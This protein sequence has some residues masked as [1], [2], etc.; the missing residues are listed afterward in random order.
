MT[1]RAAATV[2]VVDDELHNRKLVKLLL[3]HEGYVVVTASRGDEVLAAVARYAP[4]LILLDVMTPGMNGYQVATE[5]KAD[6][7]TA[8]IPIIMV[9]ALDDR[10]ARLAGLEAGAE[11]FLTKPI[12]PAELRLRVR[13]MLRIKAHGE[14]QRTESRRENA[15]L[16]RANVALKARESILVVESLTDALTGVG[17]R[18]MLERAVAAEI[19]RVERHGGA[20][21]ALMMDIDH[22]KRVNDEYGHA[23]G[24]RVLARF[25]ALLRAQTRPTDIV[26]RFGGEEFVVLMPHTPLVPAAAKAEQIR[27]AIAAE[28]IEPL[29]TP[30]TSS[31]GL[32]EL[33]QGEDAASFLGRS[34]AALYKAK[35]GGR[36]RVVAFRASDHACGGIS[37]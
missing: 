31:F 35:D 25:A 29:A 23:A 6:P 18:R 36:N 34:D 3:V 14:W 37:T 1:L 26:T 32:A 33:A 9:T 13:N 19:N 4:D 21:S 22:F 12:E 17:N 27:A 24:D 16:S 11:E 10:T 20:L 30:L 15:V 2:L 7:V 28:R 8:D 5:L